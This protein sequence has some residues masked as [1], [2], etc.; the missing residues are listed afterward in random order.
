M[1]TLY[2]KS[3][4]RVGEF[5]RSRTSLWV[6]CID[7]FLWLF[8]AGW[9]SM[10]FLRV[11]YTVWAEPLAMRRHRGASTRS[12]EQ[13]GPWA[14]RP[15]MSFRE[16][17]STCSVLLCWSICLFFSGTFCGGVM[18][19]H[20]QKR[21]P[22]HLSRRVHCLYRTLNFKAIWFVDSSTVISSYTDALSNH[23]YGF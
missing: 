3:K 14:A 20:L 4:N 15:R 10:G 22:S 12:G 21:K 23:E 7:S 5:F 9:L 13:P 17:R 2:Y 8:Y 6:N 16:Q 19:G 1:K 18:Q 11:A